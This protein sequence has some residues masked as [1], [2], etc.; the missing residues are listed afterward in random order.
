MKVEIDTETLGALRRAARRNAEEIDR[1][2]G[3]I[4]RQQLEI[5][6]LQG[7]IRQL[8]FHSCKPPLGSPTREEALEALLRIRCQIVAIVDTVVPEWQR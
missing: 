7:D 8:R 3:I 5:G 4:I 2:E 6:S 1:L